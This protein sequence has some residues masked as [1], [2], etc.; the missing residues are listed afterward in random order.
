M[1]RITA[2]FLLSSALLSSCFWG[3]EGETKHL[4]GHYYLDEV[5]PDSGAW[6]L[7][8]ADEDF[9]LADAL[10]NCQIVE[11]GFNKRCIIVRAICS[12][13]QFYLAPVSDTKDREIA[14]QAIRGPFTKQQFEAELR[15]ICGNDLPKFD[16]KLTSASTW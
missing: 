12:N 8:F 6:Y 2:L 13:P 14:R 11:A 1:S 16:S 3:D 10:F 7:H 9:G 5:Q 4:V 15:K